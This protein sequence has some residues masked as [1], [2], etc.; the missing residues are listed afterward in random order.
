MGIRQIPSSQISLAVLALV[1]KE[2]PPDQNIALAVKWMV[3]RNS[4]T[5]FWLRQQKYGGLD[6]KSIF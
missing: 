1:K 3:E 4:D 6:E 2:E 5:L